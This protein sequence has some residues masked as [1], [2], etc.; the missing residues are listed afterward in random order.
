LD[1]VLAAIE[2]F[3]SVEVP[4]SHTVVFGGLAR[5]M[6]MEREEVLEHLLVAHLISTGLS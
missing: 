6:A 5:Q 4:D 3:H 1:E 2:N